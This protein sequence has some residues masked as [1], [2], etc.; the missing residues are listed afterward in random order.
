MDIKKIK[1]IK[2]GYR[3]YNLQINDKVWN[4]QTESLGQ[5]LYKEGII[6]LSSE[7]DAISQANTLMHE[8]LH[9]IVYQWGLAEELGDKEEHI[10]NTLTNGLM[11]VFVD[12][13][14]LIS[15]LKS[16]VQEELKK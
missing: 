10:V 3:N 1:N 11:T 8:I 5:F 12:N 2:I 6:S 7:E 14:W 16:K 15:F 9:G 13:P 4:T